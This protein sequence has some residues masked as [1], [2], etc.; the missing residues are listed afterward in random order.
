MAGRLVVKLAVMRAHLKETMMVEL[1]VLP[2]AELM[3][4]QMVERLE[5][6]MVVK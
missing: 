4:Q 3:E 1:K 5:I 6:S 2:L